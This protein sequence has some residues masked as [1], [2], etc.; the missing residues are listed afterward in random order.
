MY[1]DGVVVC[2]EVVLR[3][4]RCATLVAKNLPRRAEHPPLWVG[5]HDASI[6]RAD[7]VGE[8]LEEIVFEIKW[9]A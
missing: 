6:S 3:E 4:E 7:E 8:V 1:T 2:P 5:G 9:W